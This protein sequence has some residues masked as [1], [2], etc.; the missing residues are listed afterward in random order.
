MKKLGSII[1]VLRK[2]KK[3]SQEQLSNLLG[4]TRE[5]ISQI[6]RNKCNLPSYHI[7]PLSNILCID[8]NNLIN[9]IDD[10]NSFEHYL[11][12]SKL[13]DCIEEKRIMDIDELLKNEIIINEFDYGEAMVLKLY[14]SALVEKYINNDIK[15]SIDFCLEVLN[16]ENIDCI[17]AFYPAH[18]RK[19]RYYSTIL[20]LGVNLSLIGEDLL[21]LKLLENT[22]YFLEENIFNDTLPNSTL[23]P[24]HKKSYIVF[25]NNYS[26]VL[27]SFKQFNKSLDICNKAIHFANKQSS[28]FNLELL[29]FLKTKILCELDLYEDAKKTY[30]HFKSICEIKNN[31]NYLNE[32]NTVLNSYKKLFK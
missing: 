15:K 21:H 30:M 1:A 8:L 12:A 32:K 23:N 13:I 26:D 9:H 31:I 17:E 25:L 10:Y 6:E 19:G 20:T 11:L 28:S 27:F 22:I 24:F 2:N 4:C 18:G 5:F 29:L 7:L 3:L 14:C 16:I